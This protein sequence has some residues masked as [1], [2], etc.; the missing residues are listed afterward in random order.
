MRRILDYKNFI[1]ESYEFSYDE[2]L[3]KFA[4]IAA[5]TKLGST[6]YSRSEE[7]QAET[8]SAD[9]PGGTTAE[10]PIGFGTPLRSDDK[11][12]SDQYDS[13]G[14]KIGITDKGD[15]AKTQQPSRGPIGN[16]VNSAYA[17]LNV[18]TRGIKGTS[19]G[20]LG[21]GAAASIIFYRATGYGLASGKEITLA[22][23]AIYDDLEKKSKE[24]GSNWKMITNWKQDYKPGDI[25]ITKRGSK[26]GH[27]GIVADGGLIISNS[28]GGFSGDKKGQ[29]EANYTIDS[30]D[31]VAKRNPN[32]TAIFRYSGPYKSTWT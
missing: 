3:T 22:T 29:I 14:G 9:E 10:S 1:A 12:I 27:V 24:A 25:I 8:G 31:S 11:V 19:S 21:C 28:S 20:N 30:W 2:I 15:N 7:N 18:S 5:S 13:Y 6:S 32:K 16:I 26:P 23:Q 17:N 4:R